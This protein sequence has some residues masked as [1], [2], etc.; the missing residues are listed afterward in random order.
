MYVVVTGNIVDGMRVH[1]PF[2]T[3]DDALDWCDVYAKFG[4]HIVT[5]LHAVETTGE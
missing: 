4:D 3:I 1:G 2:N 5:T